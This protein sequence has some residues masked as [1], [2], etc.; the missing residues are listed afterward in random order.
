[1]EVKC[2]ECGSGTNTGTGEQGSVKI[3][4]NCGN[5]IGWV[6]NR[7]VNRCRDKVD[8]FRYGKYKF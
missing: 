3:F 1:M 4:D 5:L 8:K 2:K 6:C 7:C